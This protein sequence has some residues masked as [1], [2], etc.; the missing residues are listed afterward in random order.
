MLSPVRVKVQQPDDTAVEDAPELVL[1][2]GLALPGALLN[3]LGEGA[4]REFD[5]HL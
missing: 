2:E 4:R 3:L 5:Y 1:G